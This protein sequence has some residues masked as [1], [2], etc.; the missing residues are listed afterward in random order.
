[1]KNSAFAC[2][3][4][5]DPGAVIV[6]NPLRVSV[7][8]PGIVRIESRRDGKF[9]NRPSQHFWNRRQ[10]VP[11]FQ[12]REIDGALLV[13]TA[14]MILSIPL[15]GNLS[16]HTVRIAIKPGSE[17]LVPLA[18]SEESN[19]GGCLRT[20]DT[21]RGR[22]DYKANEKVSVSP[23]LMSRAGWSWVD[24]SA[25]LVFNAAGFLVPREGEGCDW[26]VFA[27]GLDFAGG[28]RD[29]Y[30]IAGQV[31]LVPKW[32]LGIWWSRWE[33]YKQSDIE[34]IAADF[35]SHGV[36][37]SVCVV[38]MDW[39]LPG[40]TGY[41]WNKEFFPDPRGFFERLHQRGVRACL[42]LHPA[43]GV[44]PKEAAYEAMARH[45]GIDPASQATIKFDI[46]DPK[47]I[48][49]YFKYLHHPL[50]ADGVDFWWMDWQ[51]GTTTS[52]PGLDP[53]WYLNHLHALDLAR[54]GAKR[55]MAFS[56]W[57][58]WGAHRYPI[59]FSGDA[60]RTWDTLAFEVEVTAQSANTGFGWWSHDIGGFC[61]GLPDD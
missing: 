1:M 20:L 49:G 8:K 26:Y 17:G 27:S 61:D 13:E 54:D 44:A 29:Y 36:P 12:T 31:P 14:K 48:E 43:G 25:S 42:N 9:E 35:E 5:A 58:G 28:L 18:E 33:A 4:V 60:S 23:G 39:H 34:G 51:Q 56:R 15:D 46:T 47:F 41:T 59:G 11:E 37:L 2:D 52:V 57:G 19:L 40:W 3:P 6:C 30:A 45:M 55:A 32:A 10:E 7:L 16:G 22:W 21:V 50:E 24:D 53:L 38:D